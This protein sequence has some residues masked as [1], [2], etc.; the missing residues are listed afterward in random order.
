MTFFEDVP[1][2]SPKGGQLQESKFSTPVLLTHIP[3]VPLIPR[4]RFVPHVPPI[5]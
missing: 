2:Y 1:Y 5:S 4:I 3:T